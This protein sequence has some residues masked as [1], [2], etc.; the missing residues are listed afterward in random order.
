MES[1]VTDY[2]LLE[3]DGQSQFQT[4]GCSFGLVEG[5]FRRVESWRVWTNISGIFHVQLL[6]L[7]MVE[8][9]TI[10]HNSWQRPPR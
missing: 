2:Y 6:A 8:R 10:Q 5:R 1:L 9:C 3:T 4:D 7:R